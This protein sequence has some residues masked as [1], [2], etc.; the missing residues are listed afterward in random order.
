MARSHQGERGR[1]T[2][3]GTVSTEPEDDSVAPM[4]KRSPLT[5]WTAIILAGLL[6][7]SLVATALAVLFGS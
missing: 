1:Y 3:K 7:L 4:R 5:Y 6:A 2:P